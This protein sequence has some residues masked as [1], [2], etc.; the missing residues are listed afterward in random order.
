MLKKSG[1]MKKKK[2][3]RTDI[4]YIYVDIMKINI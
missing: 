4:Q 1:G 2:I 3:T